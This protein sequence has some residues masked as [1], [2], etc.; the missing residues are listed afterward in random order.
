[1]IPLTS[2]SAISVIFLVMNLEKLL[3]DFLLFLSSL[4]IVVELRKWPRE[5][6]WI[7]RNGRASWLPAPSTA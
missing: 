3:R 7:H 6:G 2:G 4:L 5:S 1:M